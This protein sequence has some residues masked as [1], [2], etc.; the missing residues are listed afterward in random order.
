MRILVIYRVDK[1]DKSNHGVIAK[2]LGQING[3][4]SLG[5]N[6][7]FVVNAGLHIYFNQ[8]II[9]SAKSH[10]SFKVFNFYWFKNIAHTALARQY[11]LVFIRYGLT[12]PSF[13]WFLRKLKIK[14]PNTK[15]LIDLP[16]YPY[17]DEWSGIFGQLTLMMD[18]LLKKQL[19]KYTNALTH[20]GDEKT[21]CNIPVIRITNGV[22]SKNFPIRKVPPLSQTFNMLA[23]GKWQFWH[24][25]DRLLNGIAALE[26][27]KQV[28]L[29]IVGE[30]P[31]SDTLKSLVSTLQLGSSVEFCGPLVGKSLDAL[32]DT[33]HM[34]I[35]T[36]GL[37]RKG[38]SVNS[39]LK[40]REYCA[41]GIP[42]IL[43]SNDTD[44]DPSLDFIKY[45]S[46][47]DEHIA[48]KDVLSF[49]KSISIDKQLNNKMKLY[50]LNRLD[51]QSR[52]QHI[53]ENI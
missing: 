29:F 31:E 16:T 44:F 5:H 28:R 10:T 13:L 21:I 17:A 12:T 34:A 2:M 4:Y 30:G 24:G 7:D 26:D 6:V 22:D 48:V 38:V 36:L 1:N 49:Y 9:H 27:K 33:C 50:A 52:M 43:S 18:N 15:V 53:I 37:H 14:Y 35:G 3:F 45:F 40:H 25:L 47:N 11:D 39:S 20:S 32:F 23:V 19:Y 41:R 51:W 46:A 42:F 8:E